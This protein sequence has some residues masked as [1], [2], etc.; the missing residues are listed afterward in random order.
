MSADKSAAESTASEKQQAAAQKPSLSLDKKPTSSAPASQSKPTEKPASKPEKPAPKS[1]KPVP[2]PEKPASVKNSTKTKGLLGLVLLLVLL[3]FVGL[4]ALGWLGYQQ[5]TQL[6]QQLQQQLAERPTHQALKAPLSHLTAISGLEDQQRYLQQSLANQELHLTQ[7]QQALARSNDPKPRDWQLA[8]VE[9]LL[10]LANQ[11]LQLEEDVNG[12][13]TLM[14]TAEE[15]LK[16]ANVPGA[17]GVRSDL[18]GDI[19]ELKSLPKL[20]RVSM[21]LSLQKLADQALNLKIQTLPEVPSLSLVKVTQPAELSWY[22]H[23][24]Q[25]VRGLVVVRQ[26]E[27]PI[28]ALP[29]AEDELA[30]RHQL[31]ALL[32][33][34]SWAALRGEQPLYQHSLEAATQRLT[35]FDAKQPE[36][37]ALNQQLES[38][39]QQNVKQNLPETETS[40]DSLQAFISQRYSLQLPVSEEKEASHD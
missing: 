35:G 21:A 11:R 6:E 36:I 13:L 23:L 18:L 9:Y 31:S 34:A 4:A 28:E 25:E 22:Q 8:E 3:A 15:R 7:M 40:L 37:A 27:L 10:R 17:L 39:L 19:E 12:A 32:L 2:K 33:Q 20:D 26:R 30:L 1:E 29:F 14:Q 5:L 24:W 38:L 16:Q